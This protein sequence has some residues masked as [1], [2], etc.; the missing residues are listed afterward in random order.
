MSYVLQLVL[1]SCSII[2]HSHV[3]LFLRMHYLYLYNDPCFILSLWKVLLFSACLFC[4]CVCALY[5]NSNR[6]LSDMIIMQIWR[7]LIFLKF[8]LIYINVVDFRFVSF[9]L[10]FFFFLFFPPVSLS[11]KIDA[12]L[13]NSIM[14]TGKLFPILQNALLVFGP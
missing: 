2:F 9:L 7:F 1:L 14:M 4:V 11:I 8:F 10:F 13:V 5:W 3:L 6:S 12:N